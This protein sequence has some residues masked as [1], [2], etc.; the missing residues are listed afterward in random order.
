MAPQKGDAALSLLQQF[1]KLESAGGI[2]LCA[3]AAVALVLANSPL[4]ALYAQLLELP[5]AIQLGGLAIAKPLL[6][7]VNDG[8]MAV[9]F[10]LVGLEVKRE[11]VEGELSNASN[12]ALPVVAALG[13]MPAQ[14]LSTSLA[15]GAISRPF[16]AGRS[17]PRPISPSRS[18]SLPCWGRGR[19]HRSRCSCWRWR[20][21]MISARL[22]SLRSSIPQSFPWLR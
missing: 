17:R 7:W 6:L 9:F 10:M 13:G 5:V 12:A 1:L 18:A 22:S 19:R 3:A 20:L 16:V 8:L 2:V 14:R 11:I 21:S 15:I 4:E